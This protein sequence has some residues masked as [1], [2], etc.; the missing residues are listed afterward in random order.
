MDASLQ[1]RVAEP[2]VE[3]HF[4]SAVGEGRKRV[5]RIGRD[6]LGRV[7]Y[8]TADACNG[9]AEDFSVSEKPSTC[10]GG[11]ARFSIAA[12]AQREPLSGQSSLT[13]WRQ[14]ISGSIAVD[15]GFKSGARPLKIPPGALTSGSG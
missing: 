5:R 14:G 9:K 13:G 8:Q 7:R 15:R 10:S 3:E 4:S 1:L 2:W 6:G 12:L 11:V